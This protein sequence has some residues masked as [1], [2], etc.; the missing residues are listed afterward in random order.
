VRAVARAEDV[1]WLSKALPTIP[2]A[3]ARRP[4]RIRRPRRDPVVER[5]DGRLTRRQKGAIDYRILQLHFLA[6]FRL[7]KL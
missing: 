1:A 5:F 3:E 7:Q 2:E 4:P 6:P